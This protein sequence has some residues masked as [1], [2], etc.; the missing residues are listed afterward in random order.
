MTTVGGGRGVTK[1]DIS[2]VEAGFCAVGAALGHQAGM[3]SAMSA[4]SPPATSFGGES[5]SSL[6]VT[7]LGPE[8]TQHMATVKTLACPFAVLPDSEKRHDFQRKYK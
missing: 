7:L 2:V 3:P 1:D 4:S 6:K 8:T 5:D